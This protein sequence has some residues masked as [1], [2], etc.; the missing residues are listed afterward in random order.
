M[1]ILFAFEPGSRAWGFPSPDSDYDARFV[2][3]S[4]LDWYLSIAPGRDVIELPIEGD[5][6]INGWDI[7]KALG[8]LLKPDPIS[9]KWLSSPVRYHRNEKVCDQLISLSR[10][11]AHNRTCL[12][13]YIGVGEGSVARTIAGKGAMSIKKYY[14][15]L[16]PGMALRWVRMHQDAIAP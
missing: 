14:H 6:N 9:L 4:S 16:R 7:Q 10:V 5:L 11:I 1:Q 2:Y 13:H 3:A 12:H 8:L 15:M